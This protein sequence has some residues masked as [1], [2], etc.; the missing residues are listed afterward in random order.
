MVTDL[1]A[2]LFAELGIAADYGTRPLLQ[3]Y[4]E[5]TQLEDVGPNIMGRPVELTPATAM[6]WRDMAAAAAADSVTLLPVSGYRSIEYQAMLIRKKINAGQCI[7]DI[8]MVNVA[9]GFSQ[10]HTGNAIDI[11]TPGYKPLVEE[12]DESPAFEWLST[13]AADFGFLMSYPRDNPEGV[14]YEPWHWYRPEA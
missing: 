12:F 10:H 7:D 11:A 1:H 9:P 14:I 2:A 13:R 5:A 8:L 3:R 4:R 6:A